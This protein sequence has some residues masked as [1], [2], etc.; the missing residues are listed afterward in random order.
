VKHTVT[1]ATG[2]LSIEI[3][4][5][6]NSFGFQAYRFFTKDGNTLPLTHFTPWCCLHLQMLVQ[7][8]LTSDI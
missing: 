7:Q 1:A 5:D 6:E 8:D 3:M 4:V 2:K